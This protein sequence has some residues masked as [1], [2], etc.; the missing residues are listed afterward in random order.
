[1]N[2]RKRSFKEVKYIYNNVVKKFKKEDDTSSSSSNDTSDLLDK[3][4]NGCKKDQTKIERNFN[5]IYF[6]S[7][8][9]RDSIY[10][11]SK[12]ITEAE[13]D[14]ILTKLK[15]KLDNNIPIYLHINSYGGSVY[16][17][18]A[19][20]DSIE[21]CTIP[22]HTIVEGAVASAGT[23][24]SVVGEKRYIRPNA[25]MLIHQLSSVC[26]GKMSEIEDEFKNLEDLMK[27]IK[28]IY[29]KHTSIPKKK[30]TEL[31]KHD[32]W[33]NSEKSIEYGLVDE[34]WEK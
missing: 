23:I 9:D 31:L 15:L 1:M 21:A 19:G 7:E 33:L 14:V 20:I 34:L 26:W 2:T 4:S 3:L 25:N 28:N 29:L 10:E 12:L 32:F 18:F 13:E 8:V 24:L 11:L 22:I 30:L 6:Y 17:A 5:H 27:S 16:A